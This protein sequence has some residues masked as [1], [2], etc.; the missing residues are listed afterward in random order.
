VSVTLVAYIPDNRIL[1]AVK[2]AVK[3]NR[4]LYNAE[5]ACKMSAVFSDNFNYG[6]PYFTCKFREF[7]FRE[8]FNIC[9]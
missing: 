7:V 3:R 8:F 2:N 6:A 4:Q 1:R 9:R 5:I